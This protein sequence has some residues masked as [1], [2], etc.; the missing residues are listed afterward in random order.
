MLES[1]DEVNI[2]PKTK[3]R[4][5]PETA[6]ASKPAA[7]SER[8]LEVAGKRNCLSVDPVYGQ[9]LLPRSFQVRI[10]SADQDI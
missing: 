8:R 1:H 2:A 10:K 4:R 7:A 5:N 6:S 3:S 9:T